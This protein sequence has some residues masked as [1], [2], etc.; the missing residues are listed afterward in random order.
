[1]HVQI[2]H[3]FASLKGSFQSLQELQ[4]K[5]QNKEDLYMAVC[6]LHGL[7]CILCSLW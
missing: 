3:A 6:Q 5:I 2:E 4:L 1:V 7:Q